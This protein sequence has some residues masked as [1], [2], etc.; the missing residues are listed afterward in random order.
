MENLKIYK[1]QYETGAWLEN[2]LVCGVD[3][4]G[5]GCLSGPL[6]TAAVML[7]KGKT[8]RKVKDSKLCTNLELND[9]YSWILRNSWHA[10]GIVS[11]RTIDKINIYQ[12]TLRAMRRAVNQLI[13]ISPVQPSIIL[14]DAMPLKFEEIEVAYFPRGETRSISIAAASIVAKVTRDSLIRRVDQIIPGYHL[15]KHKGYGTRLHQESIDQLGKSILHRNS[16]IEKFNQ[17]DNLNEEQ[18]TLW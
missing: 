6:V 3:E 13:S 8:S 14:V 12:A 10:I 5:R 1:N 15:D 18:Q 9:A 17:T 2:R 4:V 11:H 16:F 7:F